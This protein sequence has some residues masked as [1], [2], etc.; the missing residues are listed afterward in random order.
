MRS[1]SLSCLILSLLASSCRQYR[2]FIALAPVS[3]CELSVWKTSCYN[4]H[5]TF[6]IFTQV[7]WWR[8]SF[9]ARKSLDQSHQHSPSFL[10]SWKHCWRH[11][12]NRAAFLVSSRQP[13]D[14]WCPIAAIICSFFRLRR[15]C[16][17]WQRHHS[18]DII[19]FTLLAAHNELWY[20][21]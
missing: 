19:Y 2:P 5:L 8:H 3:M 21:E 4:I 13:P 6:C 7:C 17:R 1:Y 14:F 15:R 12:R 9:K 20:L 10:H 16:W 18:H 11:Q